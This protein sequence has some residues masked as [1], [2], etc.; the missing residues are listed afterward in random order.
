MTL[1]LYADRHGW[2]LRQMTVKLRHESARLAD[3]SDP[4]DRFIR[5]ITL[6]GDLTSE[7]RA[8]LLDIAERCSVSRTLQRA[9]QIVT[10]LAEP[11][12]TR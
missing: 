6:A 11:S 5:S 2:A 8:K 1:R 9:S 4:A 3:N 12:A 7:Q 10:E